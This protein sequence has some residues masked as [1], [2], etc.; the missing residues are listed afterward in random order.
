MYQLPRTFGPQGEF[1]S[2]PPHVSCMDVLAPSLHNSQNKRLRE[3]MFLE[4]KFEALEALEAASDSSSFSW[5]GRR[6]ARQMLIASGTSSSASE[7]IVYVVARAS[8]SCLEA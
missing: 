2:Q 6:R 4:S 8:S 1:C 7:Y 5:E 3:A